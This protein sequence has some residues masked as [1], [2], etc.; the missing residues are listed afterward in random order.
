MRPFLE[1]LDSLLEYLGDDPDMEDRITREQV[2]TEEWIANNWSDEP[3]SYQAAFATVD[4]PTG[5]E[6][7]RSIFDDIDAAENCIL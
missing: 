2:M 1:L 6:G 4:V 7:G 3:D 5:P